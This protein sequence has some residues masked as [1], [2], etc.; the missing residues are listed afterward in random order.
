[1]RSQDIVMLEAFKT[2]KANE[3]VTKNCI[4]CGNQLPPNINEYGNCI[5]YYCYDCRLGWNVPLY[6]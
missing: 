1:M 2:Q 6:E 3:A 5:S 4:D